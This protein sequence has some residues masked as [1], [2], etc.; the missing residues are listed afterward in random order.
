M[1]ERVLESQQIRTQVVVM[2]YEISMC[3]CVA[4]LMDFQA[5]S[6]TAAPSRPPPSP[7]AGA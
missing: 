3:R 4:L 1:S 6:V 7:T 5:V 2:V